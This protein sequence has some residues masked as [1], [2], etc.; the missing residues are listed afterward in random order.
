MKLNYLTSLPK[1][2]DKEI[3]ENACNFYAKY[4]FPKQEKDVKIDISFTKPE[5]G[6]AEVVWSEDNVNPRDFSLI[7]DRKV[8]G[9]RLLL[10]LAHEFVHIKQYVK[11]EM[12]DYIINSSVKWKGKKFR[13]GQNI[14][15]D[16]KNIDYYFLPWEVE[17]Y[18][19]ENGLAEYFMKEHN[20]TKSTQLY[21]RK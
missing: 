19:M 1:H 14:G 6:I 20:F 15:A 11:R 5:S 3:F 13:D 17:A 8:F 12:F 16:P 2:L 9:F 4:L 10:T 21:K 18:G 7:I